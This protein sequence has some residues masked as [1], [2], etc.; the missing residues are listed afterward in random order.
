MRSWPHG[1]LY[2]AV[3]QL[4]QSPVLGRARSRRIRRDV[5]LFLCTIEDVSGLVLRPHV[6][7]SMG[8]IA[9]SGR[10]DTSLRVH[11]VNVSHSTEPSLVRPG[12]A[13][14]QQAG[15]VASR[16]W[17]SSDDLKHGSRLAVESVVGLGIQSCSRRTIGPRSDGE[18]ARR[19]RCLF[20]ASGDKPNVLPPIWS[21][22]TSCQNPSRSPQ[23]WSPRLPSRR[24]ESESFR[25]HWAGFLGCPCDHAQLVSVPARQIR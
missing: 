3:K 10:G 18:S 12:L 11:A 25:R 23:S 9:S 16:S 21:L 19:S 22:R 4:C 15:N 8:L 1:G 17:G 6:L 13:F 14:E 24:E 2:V 5:S 7:M 20:P